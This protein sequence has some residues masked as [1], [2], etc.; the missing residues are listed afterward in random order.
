M[1]DSIK[2]PVRLPAD[3]KAWLVRE[4]HRNLG[5]QNGEVVRALRARMQAEKE[6]RHLATSS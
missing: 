5:S 2:M 6:E 4:A 3:V 1:E